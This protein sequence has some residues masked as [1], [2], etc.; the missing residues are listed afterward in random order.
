MTLIFPKNK[1]AAT[2]PLYVQATAQ[3]PITLQVDGDLGSEE[4]TIEGLGVDGVDTTTLYDC[5]GNELKLTATQPMLSFDKPARLFLTM[6]ET[7]NDVGLM[8]VD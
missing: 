6:P 5:N 3:K 4:I 1:V 8:M 7:T 2:S